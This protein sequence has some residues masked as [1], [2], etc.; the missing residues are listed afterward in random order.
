L[1]L[2]NFTYRL[3]KAG[4]SINRVILMTNLY[5]LRAH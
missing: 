2:D 3:L 5:H 1:P 4:F